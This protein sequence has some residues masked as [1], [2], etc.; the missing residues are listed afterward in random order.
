MNTVQLHSHLHSQTHFQDDD[1]ED[2]FYRVLES[3]FQDS[4][5]IMI[6]HKVDKAIEICDTVVEMAAGCVKSVYKGGRTD[7]PYE[8]NNI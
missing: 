5:V 3:E 4:T 6:A 7:E 2:M 8:V 1:T